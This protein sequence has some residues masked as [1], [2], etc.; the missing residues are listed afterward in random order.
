M[1]DQLLLL[2]VPKDSPSH[3]ERIDAFKA[4]IG[5]WTAAM[6]GESTRE[7]PKWCAMLLPSNSVGIKYH[8]YGKTEEPWELISS[9]CRILEEGGYM[10]FGHTERDALETLCDENKIPFDL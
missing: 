6:K 1:T 7:F 8:H 9:S 10:T 4:K 2:D 5:I 3:K